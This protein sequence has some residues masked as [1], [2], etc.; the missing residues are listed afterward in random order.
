M[1][2][3][4]DKATDMIHY[5][6]TVNGCKINVHQCKHSGKIMVNLAEI[7]ELMGMVPNDPAV[8]P[9]LLK[10]IEANSSINPKKQ[11]NENRNFK[12]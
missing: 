8:L 2:L 6:E 3:I 1:E 9:E 11:N 12:Q 4:S 7:A 10:I 5:I